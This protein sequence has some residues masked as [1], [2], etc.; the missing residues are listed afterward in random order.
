[1]ELRNISMDDLPL[2]E[3]ALTD[4]HMMSELGGPLPR[5]GLSEKLQGIIE[6]VEA[7]TV[8]FYVIVPDDEGDAAAGTVCIWDHDWNGTP[9]T[10]IGWM[11]LPAF[12]GRGLASEAVRSVLRRARSESRWEVIHAFPAVTNAASNSIC[13]RMGFSKIEECDFEYAGR[14]LRC[15]HW[16]LDL[17]SAGPA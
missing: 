6:S 8:W 15:N 4:P 17:R 16:G 13:R 5:Q 7:G 10:E 2:Y 9:V 14:V 12:Q 3:S 11:V 1:M